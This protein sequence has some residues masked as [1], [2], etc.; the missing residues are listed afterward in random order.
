MSSRPPKDYDY[1]TGLFSETQRKYLSDFSRDLETNPIGGHWETKRDPIEASAS[2]DIEPESS[3]ER[4][5]RTRIR[6]RLV[7]GIYDLNLASLMQERDLN[8]VV[9]KYE[10]SLLATTGPLS[11]LVELSLREIDDLEDTGLGRH[12]TNSQPAGKDHIQTMIEEPLERGIAEGFSAC[13]FDVN[14]INVDI[15]GIRRTAEVEEE[16]TPLSREELAMAHKRGRLS[17]QDFLDELDRR[18]ER[19]EPQLDS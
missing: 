8:Q 17:T 6:N 12:I 9:E 3:R 14:D 13:G 2:S 18:A 10:I 19:D 11:L 7:N 5:V 4:T 16:L 1:G 15:S